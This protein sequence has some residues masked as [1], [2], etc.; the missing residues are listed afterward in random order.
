MLL[1]ILSMQVQQW[2]GISIKCL[3]EI[4]KASSKSF[5]P[6]L[7][8]CK[9]PALLPL[10]RKNSY[11]GQDLRQA[12]WYL[13]LNSIWIKSQRTKENLHP[14]LI[15]HQANSRR[16]LLLLRW[17]RILPALVYWNEI[18]YKSFKL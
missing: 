12:C 7:H 4:A 1:K 8:Y 5:I 9:C 13:Q 18:N 16:I 10:P 17:L 15:L 3:K 14:G 6:H 11:L 2:Q